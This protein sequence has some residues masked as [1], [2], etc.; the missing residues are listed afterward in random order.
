ME[1]FI[2]TTLGVALV[3]GYDDVGF[4]TS[5]SKPFLRKQMEQQMRAICA[6]S[7]TKNDVVHQSLEQYREVYVRA[8]AQIHHLKNAVRKY[9]LQQ[10]QQ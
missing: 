3:T 8:T 10:Q 2:P 7:T 5:L 4:E 1:E 6:G 9:C